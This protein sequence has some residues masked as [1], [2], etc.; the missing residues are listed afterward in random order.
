VRADLLALAAELARRGEPFVL[1]VVVRREPSSSAQ[2]GDAA[3]ITATGA[4]HGW[5][6]GACAAPSVRREAERVLADGRPRLLQLSA[7]PSR[8][9]RAGITALPVGCHS[10]G[11]VEIFLEPVVPAPRV[12]VFGSSPAARSVA[13]VG[14]AMGYTSELIAPGLDPAAAPAGVRLVA[15]LDDEAARATCREPLHVVVA[16]MGEFDED[17]VVAA[18]AAEPRYLGVVASR[19]RFAELCESLLARGVPSSALDLIRNPA[20]LDIGARRPEE[21]AVSI[22]AEIVQLRREAEVAASAPARLSLAPSPLLPPAVERAGECAGG[23]ATERAGERS[24]EL[25]AGRAADLALDP[26]CGMTVEIA[27]AR[28]R[29]DVDGVTYVFCC[30][31][32]RERFAAAPASFLAP[33]GAVVSE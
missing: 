28:H 12:R 4:Y 14:A 20:G 1:A 32:C 27:G 19:R 15:S 5:I 10:G 26:V 18:L 33:A 25:A 6:G 24:L 2:P 23:P 8:E 21:L 16:T 22:Y 13:A 11:T 30:S 7:D 3:V 29:H 31:R 9:S 17:A